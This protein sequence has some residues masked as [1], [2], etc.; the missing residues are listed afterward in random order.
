VRAVCLRLVG[1]L[2]FLG[3]K[4]IATFTKS[5]GFDTVFFLL[6]GHPITSTL[7][8]TSLMGLALGRYAMLQVTYTHT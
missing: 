4:T 6:G 2:L 1:L 5:G 3:P 7:L 8:M